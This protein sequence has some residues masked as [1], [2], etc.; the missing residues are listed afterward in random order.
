MMRYILLLMTHLLGMNCFGQSC[1]GELV[2]K[3]FSDV[4]RYNTVYSESQLDYNGNSVSLS[5]RITEST[6]NL[7]EKRPFILLMHGG[8]FSAGTPSLMDSIATEFAKRGY[9]TASIQYRLGFIGS[10]LTCPIDTVELIR[11]WYRATQDAKSAVRYFKEKH[12]EFKLDTNLF[13]AG[14]WSAGGYVLPGLIWM[15]DESEKPGQIALLSDTSIN[16]QTYAR[17]DLGSING[18]TNLNGYST[19]VKGIFSF[20]SSYLFPEHLDE[21][22]NTAILSFN[23]KQDEFS[24]PW[25][26]CNLDVWNYLCPQGLPQACGIVPVINLL[27]L[28]QIPHQYNLFDTPIC[29]HNLH[30]PCFPMFQE[31][32]IQIALFLN[33]L[34]EC[35]TTSTAI[36]SAKSSALAALI[37]N[38]NEIDDF[39]LKHLNWHLIDQKG[40]HF[41]LSKDKSFCKG[42]YHCINPNNSSE[43]FRVIIQ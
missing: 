3:E 25:E 14:G 10:S 27:N 12:E 29:S 2:S 34:S 8:G 37:I 13:F 30:D 32:I 23:N 26:T 16:G 33:E 42:L 41:Q 20:S 4:I 38:E 6:E 1:C 36:N 21:T 28:Y 18:T 24:I 43:S 11:A 40:T 17:P 19:K 39:V 9:V 31:E 7:C 15:N 5:A 35:Q 22:E